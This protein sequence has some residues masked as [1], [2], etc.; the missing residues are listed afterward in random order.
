MLFGNALNATEYQEHAKMA[1]WE[2]IYVTDAICDQCSELLTCNIYRTPFGCACN[3]CKR[4][5]RVLY[6]YMNVCGG[7]LGKWLKSRDIDDA[8]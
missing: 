1:N 5:E 8:E 2:L 6:R 7:C 4:L 3:K